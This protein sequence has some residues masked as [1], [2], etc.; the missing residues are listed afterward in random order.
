MASWPFNLAHKLK[1]TENILNGNETRETEME[2]LLC[3]TMNPE[4]DG[5]ERDRSL[6]SEKLKKKR[7]NDN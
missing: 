4:T 2:A 7:E 1:R 5:Y 6:R 3:K